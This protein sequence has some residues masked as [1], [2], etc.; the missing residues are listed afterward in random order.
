M[1]NTM[2]CQKHSNYVKPAIPIELFI[3]NSVFPAQTQWCLGLIWK[4]VSH[5]IIEFQ[6]RE[7]PDLT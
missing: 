4:R 5:C 6:F 2:H 1:N 3:V 7:N